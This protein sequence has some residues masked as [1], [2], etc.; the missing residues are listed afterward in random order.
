MQFYLE[1]KYLDMA[2]EIRCDR[3]GK[4]FDHKMRLIKTISLRSFDSRDRYYLLDTL[5]LDLCPNCC[6]ELKQWIKEG[7]KHD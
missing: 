7:V 4:P 6:K 3:C 5:I 2:T 1:R